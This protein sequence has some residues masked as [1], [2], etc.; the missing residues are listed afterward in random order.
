MISHLSTF[1][2]GMD[3][4]INLCLCLKEAYNSNSAS[5][6]LPSRLVCIP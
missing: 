5:L 6:R 2:F 4:K 1:E 3:N